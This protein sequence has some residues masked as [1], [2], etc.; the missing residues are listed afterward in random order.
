MQG[1]RQ[2]AIWTARDTDPKRLAE[3]VERYILRAAAEGRRRKVISKW[4]PNYQQ[5]CAYGYIVD[6]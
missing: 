4:V 2:T 5:Y 1:E 6:A 3:T